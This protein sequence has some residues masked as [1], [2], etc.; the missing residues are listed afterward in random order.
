MYRQ[1]NEILRFVQFTF[2]PATLELT[3]DGDPVAIEPQSIRLLEYL[4]RHRDHVVSRDDLVEAIWQGRAISDWAISGAIKAL[5]TALGDLGREKQF[6]RTVH[7]RGYRFVANVTVQNGDSGAVLPTILVRLFRAPSDIDGVAY[8][9]DGLCEDLIAGLSRQNAVKVLPFHFSRA[10]SEVTPPENAG[11]T[12]IVDGNVRQFDGA[13]RI[14][15]SVLDATG[16]GQLWAERFDLTRAS[17]L[18]GHHRITER[19]LEVVT[20]GQ[21]TATPRPRGTSNSEAY[22]SYLKGR[23]AYFRYEPAAFVQ[24]LAHFSKAA[25]LD[26]GFADAFAQQSYCRTTLYVFGLPGADLTLDRAGALA[27]QAIELDDNSALGYARLGWVLGYLGQPEATI[28]AFE[29]AL[30]RD[31]GN[32]EVYLAYGETMN[33]LARPD[34]AGPL[35]QKAFS[36]DNYPPPSWEFARGH[37]KVLLGQQ[38]H[39]ISHFHAVLERIERFIPARVQLARAYWEAGRHEDATKMVAKIRVFAPKFGLAHAG[40]MFPYPLEKERARL[41]KALT[42]AGL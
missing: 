33:R 11:I 12:H 42:G 39:A 13:I 35:L 2:T 5:R 38:D 8:L 21:P 36:G 4:I 29:A 16:T 7:S 34:L 10:L 40:R 41:V 9:A 31:L 19:I 23:Y 28:A 17:L 27:R 26:P 3:C 14:H 30:A 32:P 15:V 22:D 18:A 24:A 1:P 20:P 6:V 37:A 25:K